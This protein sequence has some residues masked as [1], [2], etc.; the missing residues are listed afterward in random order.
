MTPTIL[1]P[2]KRSFFSGALFCDAKRKI[3][4]THMPWSVREMH[5]RHPDA[6][7]FRVGPRMPG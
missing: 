3:P 4:P 5:L 7:V 2:P 1:D 6:F